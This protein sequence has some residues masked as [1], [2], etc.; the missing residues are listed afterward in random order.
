M[1]EDSLYP[2]QFGD[3]ASMLTSSAAETREPVKS[4]GCRLALGSVA[5]WLL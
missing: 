4:L 3:L 5:Y 2:E 1:D